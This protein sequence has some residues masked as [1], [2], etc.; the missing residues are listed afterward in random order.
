ME[1]Q[2]LIEETKAKLWRMNNEKDIDEFMEFVN[3][4][5]WNTD[6]DVAK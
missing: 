3:D 6:L 4:V 1:W 2:E 5:W